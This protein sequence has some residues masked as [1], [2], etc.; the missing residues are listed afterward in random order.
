MENWIEE[1]K[2]RADQFYKMPI[3]RARDFGWN[4]YSDD[5]SALI[6]HV[7]SLSDAVF[8]LTKHIRSLE[9]QIGEAKAQIA[10]KDN[11]LRNLLDFAKAHVL[12]GWQY[13]EPAIEEAEAQIGGKIMNESDYWSYR[14]INET[15]QIQN[16]YDAICYESIRPSTV[17]KP[18]LFMDGNQWCALYGEN[19]QDGVAGFGLSPEK[20][21]A[22]FD[23]AWR[24]D[25]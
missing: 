13:D 6:K 3:D 7:H 2:Q 8:A 24:Q 16:Y 19:L 5:L 11:A 20:A 22:A 15:Q 4:H 14:N 1:L 23:T 12:T 21:M 18:R 17:Y 25:Q 9:V 10:K